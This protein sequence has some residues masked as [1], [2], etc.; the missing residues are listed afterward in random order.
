M[1]FMSV[2]MQKQRVIVRA[3]ERGAVTSVATARTAEQMNLQQG[4]AWH[5][6]V[7]HAVLRCPGKARYFLDVPNWQRLRRRRRHLAFGVIAIL[8]LALA[9]AWLATHLR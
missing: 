2:M 3:F 1:V 8:L 4:M 7:A 6:L 5:H 9:L